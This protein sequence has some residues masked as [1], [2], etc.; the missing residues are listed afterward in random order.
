MSVASKIDYYYLLE[1]RPQKKSYRPGEK[2]HLTLT[3]KNYRRRLVTRDIVFPLA[4]DIKDGNYPVMVTSGFYFLSLDFSLNPSKYIPQHP[5]RL[6]EILNEDI[7]AQTL[8]VFMFDSSSDVIVGG[9]KYQD[10]P[11]FIVDSLSRSRSQNRSILFDFYRQDFKMP[12]VVMGAVK[13]DL[14]VKKDIYEGEK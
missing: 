8:S 13:L 5:D 14:Q 1:A 4:K 2:V 10:L 11:Q 9:H 6:F 3:F 7:N 12:S